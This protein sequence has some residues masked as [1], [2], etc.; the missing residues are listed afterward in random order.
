MITASATG[1][2]GPAISTHTVT[3]AP[4]VGTPVFALGANSI[5]CMGAAT[6]NYGA[7][8]SNSTGI[9]YSLDAL[10]LLGGNSIDPATGDVT[11][12]ALW[13]GSSVITATA[14]GCNGPRSATHTVTI[15]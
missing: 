2:N 15:D 7:T 4:L 14:A 12:S 6:I 8:A 13:V 11:F 1:C 3:I 9:T 10:S 5:R